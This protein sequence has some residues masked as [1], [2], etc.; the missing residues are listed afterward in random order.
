MAAINRRIAWILAGVSVVL[1]PGPAEGTHNEPNNTCF[2]YQSD[3]HGTDGA[4]YHEDYNDNT[5]VAVMAA[6]PD[7]VH[8]RNLKDRICLQAGHDV[9]AY[10]ESGGDDLG[11]GVGN[12]YLSGSDGDDYLNAHDGENDRCYGGDGFD[13]ILNCETVVG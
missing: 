13:T 4:D 11:G 6:G 8:G 7:E 3:I 5:L 1:I 9:G 10:G 12:D 2:G